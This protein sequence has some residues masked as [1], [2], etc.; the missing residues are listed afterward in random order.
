MTTAWR[1]SR[2]RPARRSSTRRHGGSRSTVSRSPPLP[3]QRA[4][5]RT[6]GT[7]DAKIVLNRRTA[8][9]LEALARRAFRAWFVD[10]DPI[11]ARAAGEPPHGL[12]PE[13]AGLFPD[14]L[15]ET[16]IGPAP[17]GWAVV[18]LSDLIEI[19]PRRTLKKGVEAPYVPMKTV[20]ERGGQ[21]DGWYPRA[22]TSGTKFANG[23]T[24]MARIT[25][26]LE[27]GKT[28]FVD[29]L[30]DEEVGWGSTEF[31]V[32]RPKPPAPAAFAY[33][34]ARSPE[35]RDHAIR[36]MTGTSGRQRV[37]ADIFDWFLVAR[38]P[39]ELLERFG[40]FVDPVMTHVRT[41]HEQTVTL[42]ATRDRLLPKLIG[43]ELRVS[44][45]DIERE[46]PP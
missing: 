4:I 21:V 33:L 26:C 38:P 7:L 19:N 45:T 8:A 39:A 35:L 28:A 18:P 9:T 6:L 22:F 30:D 46:P 20:P 36:N 41:L 14:R 2:E 29:F 12:P 34:L 40:R 37:P 27:N 5:A 23:D 43:G 25:P 17:A 24:L 44:V 1:C 42:A 16:E 32:L 3:E 10:F 13:I 31:H 11:R 15:E